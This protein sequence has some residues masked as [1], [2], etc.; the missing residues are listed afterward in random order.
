MLGT[1]RPKPG[2]SGQNL[3]KRHCSGVIW[4]KRRT[5]RCPDGHR[6]YD[7]LGRSTK[8]RPRFRGRFLCAISDYVFA[9]VRM[10]RVQ[11][12][13]RLPPRRFVCKFTCCLRFVAMLLLLRLFPTN[14]PRSHCEHSFPISFVACILLRKFSS[15]AEGLSIEV[16]SIQ[17]GGLEK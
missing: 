11:T 12:S 3:L 1:N 4:N 17:L 5:D 13:C 10:H 15:A 16:S 2:S 14:P 9:A 8:K 6:H 7:P